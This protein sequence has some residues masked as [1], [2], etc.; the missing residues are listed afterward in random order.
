LA[1]AGRQI[2]WPLME[3]RDQQMSAALKELLAG[4]SQPTTPPTV[5]RAK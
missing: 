2:D 4:S 3:A 1:Q 5:P